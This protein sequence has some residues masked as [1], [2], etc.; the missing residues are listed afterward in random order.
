VIAY[1]IELLREYDAPI[2]SLVVARAAP[3]ADDKRSGRGRFMRHDGSIQ[4]WGWRGRC[5]TEE[6]AFEQAN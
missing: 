5:L 3:K 4:V 6:A 2:A 1:P